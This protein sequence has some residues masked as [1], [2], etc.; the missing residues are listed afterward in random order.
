M[1][2][3]TLFSYWA[4][5]NN[6]NFC[7]EFDTVINGGDS[8]TEINRACA[9]KISRL[10]VKY[11]KYCPMCAKQ[12][13][14]DYGETYWHRQHQLPEMFY[15][16]KHQIR[17]VESSVLLQK[18]AKKFYPASNE[19]PAEY[20]G[21]NP[22]I[23]LPYKDKLIKIGQEIEW[24]INNGLNFDWSAN[25]YEKYRR[26]LRDKGLATV[27]GNC[28]NYAEIDNAFYDYWGKDFIDI[29]FSS[30][31]N[32]RFNGW[33]RKIG[34]VAMQNYTPLYHIIFMCFL[35]GNIEKFVNS[36]PAETPFGHP[37]YKCENQICSHYRKDGAKMIG[38]QN[39]DNGLV[40]YFECSYCG[41]L[42]KYKK[43][44]NSR[45]HQVIIVD[46]GN[47]WDSELR[48][49]CRDPKITNKQ[50][51]EILKCSN[52][53]LRIQKKKRRLL[54]FPAGRYDSEKTLMEYYKTIV[55]E[56]CEQYEEVTIALLREK[57][58]G[59]YNYLKHYD[60]K[61][62]RSRVVYENERRFR[63]DMEHYKTKVTEICE[64]Y[65]EVTIALLREKVP[66]AYNYLKH[67]DSKW[68]RSRVVY[69]TERR[70]HLDRENL[71]LSKLREIIAVFETEGY[72]DRQLSYG[73][74]ASLVGS[75]R[76]ELRDKKN[77]NSELRTFLD[78]IIEHSKTWRQ[79]RKAKIRGHSS[80]RGTSIL[81]KLRQI[82]AVF[83]AEGYPDKQLSYDLLAGLAGSTHD[84]LLR[85][86]RQN[87]EL[88]DFLNEIVEHRKI[89]RQ[90]RKSK[91]NECRSKR[92]NL[93]L[94]AIEQILAAPP[95]QQISR[96][97]VAK[98]AGLSR[99]VLKDD[100]YLSALT[101]GIVEND[102]D[103]LKRRL[104]TAYHS[105]PTENR[106]YSTFAICRAAEIDWKTCTKYWELF[107][108]IIGNLNDKSID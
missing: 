95:R 86:E 76:E 39:A 40:G 102:M 13:I 48:R 92:E 106:P 105:K 57:A 54:K 72:P 78:E 97:Y 34:K 6:Q 100:H 4:V 35:A 90:E 45:E 23:F 37:P 15:C 98:V 74:V 56:I 49:C 66:G 61:W 25:G 82:I 58:P 29:L 3:H 99:D 81:S 64:Q 30:F 60:S 41:M 1:F 107:E 12:D 73:F 71:L 16:V 96:N 43:S 101:N 83:D 20:C 26:M 2:N 24:L 51:T 104:M 10:R 47:L 63:P 8:A 14:N 75:T 77:P 59:A 21:E 11:L 50:A 88:S 53:V 19:V 33:K 62:I 80:K 103:W 67:Y 44:N 70:F 65:E 84:E 27:K 69:E 91:I 46:Y 89:W 87:P 79:E 68:I 31:G 55:T 94:N 36:N 18:T 93:I 17:L 28:S 32:F 108:K 38:V 7:D 5:T 9:R 85:E 42:Y 52:N 22:D